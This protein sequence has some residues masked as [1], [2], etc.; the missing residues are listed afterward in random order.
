[1]MIFK[2]NSLGEIRT[3]L[4]EMTTNTFRSIFTWGSR[5]DKGDV[6]KQIIFCKFIPWQISQDVSALQIA[7]TTRTL[8]WF[9]VKCKIYNSATWKS[10]EI[11]F[12]DSP[13]VRSWNRLPKWLNS[14]KQQIRP[15]ILYSFQYGKFICLEKTHPVHIDQSK[16]TH[17]H[18]SHTNQTYLNLSPSQWARALPKSYQ[19]CWILPWSFNPR[20]I[21][22]SDEKMG[23]DCL[24]LCLYVC[25]WLCGVFLSVIS[26]V[27]ESH[28]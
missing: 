22:M 3:T 8:T 28:S 5:R 10:C 19:G 13:V 17:T 27:W 24:C 15:Y 26:E 20:I 18:T 1:M 23:F 2:D 9:S 11:S 14:L 12:W 25:A 16:H 4:C 7:Q 21:N 6:L